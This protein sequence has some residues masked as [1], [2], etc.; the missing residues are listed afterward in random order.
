M[1]EMA[2]FCLAGERLFGFACDHVATERATLDGD[3][4][5]RNLSAQTADA[6]ST[7]RTGSGQRARGTRARGTRARSNLLPS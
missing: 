1:Q 3:A 2:A 7:R 6:A 5:T 4:S